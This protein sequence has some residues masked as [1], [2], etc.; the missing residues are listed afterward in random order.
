MLKGT[1]IPAGLFALAD[2]GKLVVD[3]AFEDE[4]IPL[5]QGRIVNFLERQLAHPGSDDTGKVIHH[6]N[7]TVMMEAM[8]FTAEV[9]TGISKDPEQLL[10]WLREGLGLV[11][12]GGHG[13]GPCD[14]ILH[15]ECCEHPDV[16]E[17]LRLTDAMSQMSSAWA[18]DLKRYKPIVGLVKAESTID[19]GVQGNWQHIHDI[20]KY[21]GL[22]LG[23]NIPGDTPLGILVRDAI[24]LAAPW[25]YHGTRIQLRRPIT[26]RQSR[27][28]RSFAHPRRRAGKLHVFKTLD[29]YRTF[30]KDVPVGVKNGEVCLNEFCDIDGDLSFLWHDVRIKK[31]PQGIYY[32]E[33]RPM[34]SMTVEEAR[35]FLAM[36]NGLVA[37]IL[38]VLSG[39]DVERCD[40]DDLLELI[41]KRLSE[42]T[43]GFIPATVP[44]EA[45]WEDAHF[46]RPELWDN[47]VPFAA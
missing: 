28:L 43:D 23:I 19:G 17:K 30:L 24:H 32:I 37:A 34:M 14:G 20:G 6:D 3:M 45:E 15:T 36:M 2:P 1:K 18:G 38:D 27:G 35:Q 9:V 8:Q 7:L 21:I 33:F 11:L 5:L 44:S 26:P 4:V 25:V 39:K 10:G 29:N 16:L 47:V 42:L 46:R 40:P 12:A 22:H 41:F 13:F 31:N